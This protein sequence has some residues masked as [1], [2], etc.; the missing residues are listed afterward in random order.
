MSRN[1]L[2]LGALLVL[3]VILILIFRS[4]F[5]GASTVEA[6]PLM[7]ALEAITPIRIE[8]GGSAE[9]PITIEKT[10]G[11]WRV[12]GLG[13]FPAVGNKIERLFDDLEQVTVRRPVVSS[14]RYH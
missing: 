1:Q 9:E 3:Q 5:A 14:S 7:P 13:V 11:E 4:P 6:R 10:A 2:A 8:L 12:R